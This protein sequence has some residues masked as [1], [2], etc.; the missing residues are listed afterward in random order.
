M[1]P[2]NVEPCLRP[3]SSLSIFPRR[4]LNSTMTCCRNTRA[5]CYKYVCEPCFQ[6]VATNFSRRPAGTC[7]GTFHRHN[8]PRESQHQNLLDRLAFKG[9][10]VRSDDSPTSADGWRWELPSF[11]D[12]GVPP[13]SSR[14]TNSIHALRGQWI[15]VVGDSRARFFLYASLISLLGGAPQGTLLL[16]PRAGQTIE[17]RCK[18]RFARLTRSTVRTQ[19][20]NRWSGGSVSA[21]I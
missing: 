16:Y 18:A 14:T 3:A 21:T 17:Y 7:A 11:A 20:A 8:C 19:G 10:W 13:N 9:K 1:S 2:Q 4:L 6:N 15:L 12:P 5:S